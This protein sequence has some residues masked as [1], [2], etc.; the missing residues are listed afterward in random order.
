MRRPQ[1]TFKTHFRNHVPS[2]KRTWIGLY[3]LSHVG[4]VV[5]LYC[6]YSEMH[7]LFSRFASWRPWRG[8]NVPAVVPFNKVCPWS[9]KKVCGCSFFSSKSVGPQ[10]TWHIIILIVLGVDGPLL[11]L[12][13]YKRKI[14]RWVILFII[15][16]SFFHRLIMFPE[17]EQQSV[18]LLRAGSC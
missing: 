15:S 1:P 18:Y 14:E 7:L 11:V 8:W 17:T 10:L 9:W 13:F 4:C 3:T 16:I 6:E 2:V 5:M 12:A